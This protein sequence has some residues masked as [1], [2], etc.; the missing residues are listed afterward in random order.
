MGAYYYMDTYFL[1]DT[2]YTSKS[3]KMSRV[4]NYDNIIFQS[5]IPE[6]K[7]FYEFTI[8]TSHETRKEITL[9]Q[10]IKIGAVYDTKGYLHR[11]LVKETFEKMLD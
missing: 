2:F 6:G 8:K 5:K 9:D 11:Y 7:D 4:K 10:K 1:G 3:H